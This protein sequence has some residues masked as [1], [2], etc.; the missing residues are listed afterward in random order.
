MRSSDRLSPL[1]LV[2]LV[3]VLADVLV[4]VLSVRQTP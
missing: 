2:L 3:L 1:S 4:V